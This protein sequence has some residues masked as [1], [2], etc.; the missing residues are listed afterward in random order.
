MSAGRL[1]LQV[2]TLPAVAFALGVQAFT[3]TLAAART[4]PD[5]REDARPW[6]PDAGDPAP[7]AAAAAGA[8]Q[9]AP[10]ARESAMQDF[11]GDDLKLFEWH[12]WFTKKGLRQILDH[13]F[14]V[15]EGPA[16]EDEIRGKKKQQIVLRLRQG[17][18]FDLPVTYQW[19]EDD[20]KYIAVSVTLKHRRRRDADELEQQKV[21]A[22]SDIVGTLRDRL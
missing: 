13:G 8:E 5:M 9:R 1:L 15:E 10:H 12:A 22:L 4:T 19:R 2:A 16:T 11:G 18:R 21:D 17:A 6:I 14:E 20:A 3:R 7:G